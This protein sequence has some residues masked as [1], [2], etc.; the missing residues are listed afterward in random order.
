M[1]QRLAYIFQ[2]LFQHESIRNNANTERGLDL[3]VMLEMATG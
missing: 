1:Q 3:H 2:T